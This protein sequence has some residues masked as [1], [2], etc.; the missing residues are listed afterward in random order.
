MTEPGAQQSPVASMPPTVPPPPTP[1]GWQAPAVR[2]SHRRPKQQLHR[3]RRLVLRVAAVAVLVLALGGA[4]VVV[5][6]L[7]ARS[8]LAAA[9]QQIPALRQQIV[10]GDQQ[11]ASRQLAAVTAETR[12]ARALTSDPVWR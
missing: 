6:G 10:H 9:S 1:A 4:W 8:Q 7:Q 11:G 5:R 3:R 12:K 2:A